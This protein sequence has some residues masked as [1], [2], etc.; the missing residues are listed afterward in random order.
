MRYE[1]AVVREA[2]RGNYWQLVESLLVEEKMPPPPAPRARGKEK[3]DIMP[4]KGRTGGSGTLGKKRKKGSK[5]YKTRPTKS[6]E[7][8]ISGPPKNEEEAIGKVLKKE[9]LDET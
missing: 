1:Q 8:K 5:A 7:G 3:E 9:R 6:S 2:D 4:R